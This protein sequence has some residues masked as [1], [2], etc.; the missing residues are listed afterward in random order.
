MT[1]NLNEQKNLRGSHT[2]LMA[3]PIQTMNLHIK[4]IV[5]LSLSPPHASN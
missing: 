3:T 4:D 2:G 5:D 1:F